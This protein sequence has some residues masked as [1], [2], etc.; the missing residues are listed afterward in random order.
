[1]TYSP[2]TDAD[3]TDVAGAALARIAAR[4]LREALVHLVHLRRPLDADPMDGLSEVRQ[5]LNDLAVVGVV[6]ADAIEAAENS[7]GSS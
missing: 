3:L 5:R 6:L 4:S 1:M 2:H 7:A